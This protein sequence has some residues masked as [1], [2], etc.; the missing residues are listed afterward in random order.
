MRDL[1]T[2]REF[3]IAASLVSGATARDISM[4]LGLSFH[5]VRTHIRNLYAKVGVSNRVELVHY[6]DTVSA[7]TRS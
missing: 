2:E 1:M 7:S 6:M 4:E 5:T 3:E